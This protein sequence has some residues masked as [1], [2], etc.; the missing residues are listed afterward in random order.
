MRHELDEEV[1]DILQHYGIKGM[2][3]DVRRTPEQLAE[4]RSKTREIDGYIL[5]RSGVEN[6]PGV[7]EWLGDE[8]EDLME[9]ASKKAK[10]ILKLTKMRMK[11]IRVGFSLKGKEWLKKHQKRERDKSYNKKEGQKAVLALAY[12]S[13]LT[14]KRP[15]KSEINRARNY[16]Y[17]FVRD[18]KGH[19]KTQKNKRATTVAKQ[20]N[21][22]VSGVKPARMNLRKKKKTFYDR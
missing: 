11:D 2:K 1:E 22:E 12:K 3:W 13:I 9:D 20:Y 8:A 10:K 21:D 17:A 4:A 5:D 19:L 7:L 15:S 18:F 6:N 16:N 14:G